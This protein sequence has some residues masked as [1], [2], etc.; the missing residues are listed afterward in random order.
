MQFLPILQELFESDTVRILIVGVVIAVLLGLFWKEQKRITAALIV[1]AVVYAACELLSNLR[2]NFL[3]EIVL[4]F[5]G[6]AA[7][8]CCIGFLASLLFSILRKRNNEK[9]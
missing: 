2:S 7:L 9:P 4:V 3:I 1:S 6:T 8:G 5:V